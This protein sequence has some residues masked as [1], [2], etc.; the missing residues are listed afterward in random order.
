MEEIIIYTHL[1]CL[2]KNNGKNH[3]EK[4]ERLE[5]IIN[6][7]KE[8]NI[9]PNNKQSLQRHK[10]RSEYWQVIEGNGK[11]YLEDSEIELK[12]GENIFIPQ[13]SLHRLE[14]TNTCNLKIIEIQ[15]GKVI[16][17]DDIER[18]EDDYGRI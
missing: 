11:V 16:S 15:I 18:I 3:P 2:L 14:N 9:N 4:K 10:Y 13:G 12:S 8:M 6:S 1:D 17:E 7:I 5:V